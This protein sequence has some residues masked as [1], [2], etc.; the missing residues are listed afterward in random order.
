MLRGDRVLVSFG[1][2]RL[3]G[4]RFCRAV[5]GGIEFGESAEQALRREF[6]E[7]LAVELEAVRAIGVLENLFEYEGRQGHEIV[8]LFMIESVQLSETELDQPLRIRD[9][10]EAAGWLPISEFDE[11]SLPL[12]PQE[13]QQILLAEWR[14]ASS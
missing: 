4:S 9:T 7:E 14:R 2:D 13:C 6:R 11:A 10:G 5:G 12:Y 1:E 3:R 8:H